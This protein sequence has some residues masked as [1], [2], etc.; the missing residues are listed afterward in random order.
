MRIGLSDLF[1]APITT[2]TEGVEVFGEPFRAVQKNKGLIQADLSSNVAEAV[3]YADD[4]VAARVK[5]F[6]SGTLTIQLADISTARRAQ[7]LGEEQDEDGVNYSSGGDIA[8]YFAAGFRSR[9]ADGTY[10]YL[11]FY[12]VMFSIPTENHATKGSTITFQT[13]TIVGSIEK[14]TDGKW[15]ADW[16]GEPSDPV[17]V[18]WFKKVREPRNDTPGGDTSPG[19]LN[20]NG[21]GIAAGLSINGQIQPLNMKIGG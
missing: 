9:R 18:G 21:Q 10:R 19:G 12:K 3:L 7:I 5:E 16:T 17:A 1:L 2:T 14:R 4:G 11:W 15:K 20:I 13:P 6:S 8:P